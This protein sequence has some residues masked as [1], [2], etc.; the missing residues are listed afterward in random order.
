MFLSD[1]FYSS[2]PSS[3]TKSSEWSFSFI[4]PNMGKSGK[5]VWNVFSL[6]PSILVLIIRF[7]PW[8][9]P[10]KI[11]NSE[12]NLLVLDAQSTYK[13]KWQSTHGQITRLVCRG[14]PWRVKCSVFIYRVSREE[15]T[16]LRESVPYVKL[17]RY[18]P[19]HL[20]PKLDG[21][22]DN[23]HRKVWASRVPCIVRRP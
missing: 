11:N 17:N 19:K 16:K 2:I 15:W 21:Y 12:T 10:T 23:G 13:W 6:Q 7:L 20:Y 1:P 3:I 5:I 8:L 9:T 4:L 18:N 22:G 14:G